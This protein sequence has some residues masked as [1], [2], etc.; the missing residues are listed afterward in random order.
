MGFAK[1]KNNSGFTLIE[2]LITIAVISIIAAVMVTNLGGQQKK[3]RDAK[4]K[5]DLND[6]RNALQMYYND[7]GQYPPS[8]IPG[9][10]YY[11][12]STDPQPWISDLVSSYIKE[13]PTDPKNTATPPNFYFYY[14]TGPIYNLVT[15]LENKSDPQAKPNCYSAGSINFNYCI[16]NP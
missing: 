12:N 8:T 10:G 16:T 5:A 9:G 15:I 1:R 14:T 4:R 11:A 3:A 6:I 13:L 2:L 7:K